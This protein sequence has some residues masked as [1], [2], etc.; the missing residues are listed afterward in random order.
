MLPVLSGRDVV[1]VP[2]TKLSGRTGRRRARGPVT[3][4]EHISQTTLH[5]SSAS[6]DTTAA[7]HGNNSGG[8]GQDVMAGE[9][10]RT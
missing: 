3:G 5:V 9:A 2:V 7:A 4:R 6:P 10:Q 8:A 1:L